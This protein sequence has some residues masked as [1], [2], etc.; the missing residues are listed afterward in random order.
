MVLKVIQTSR[1][2]LLYIQYELILIISKYLLLVNNDTTPIYHAFVFKSTVVLW[3]FLRLLSPLQLSECNSL[4]QICHCTRAFVAVVKQ[5]AIWIWTL[6]TFRS[7]GAI[8]MITRNNNK[9]CIQKHKKATAAS[10]YVWGPAESVFIF[11]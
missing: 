9:P 10:I 3:F 6:F 4:L 7:Q 8:R 5:Y 11:S 1:Y 2:W